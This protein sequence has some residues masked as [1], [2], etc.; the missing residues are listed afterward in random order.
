MKIK[1]EAMREAIDFIKSNWIGRATHWEGHPE[2]FVG[3]TLFGEVTLRDVEGVILAMKEGEH[4]DVDGLTGEITNKRL[5][6]VR[7]TK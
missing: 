6:K 1:L 3:A 4:V 7:V 5:I 2:E